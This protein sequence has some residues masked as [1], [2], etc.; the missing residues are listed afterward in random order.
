MKMLKQNVIHLEGA[1]TQA[2][3]TIP[4]WFNY[5]AGEFSGVAYKWLY[6]V[7]KGFWHI[8]NITRHCPN[9]ECELVYIFEGRHTTQ[10][11]RCP[12]CGKYYHPHGD[13]YIRPLVRHSIGK[14]FGIDTKAVFA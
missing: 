1:T 10:D 8:V 12:L 2:K 7:D 9:D 14:K 5:R 11:Y 4:S 3:T 13:E 6:G